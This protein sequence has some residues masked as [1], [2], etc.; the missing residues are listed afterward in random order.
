VVNLYLE[1]TGAPVQPRSLQDGLEL[2]RD[3]GANPKAVELALH[4]TSLHCN[5]LQRVDCFV[6]PEEGVDQFDLCTIAI[7]AFLR[8]MERRQLSTSHR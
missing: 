4:L 5:P 7:K 8:D 2:L 6:S 1:R 3:R